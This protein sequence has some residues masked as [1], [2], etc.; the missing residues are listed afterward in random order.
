MRWPNRPPLE[1]APTAQLTRETGYCSTVAVYQI[2]A[3][4]R[5]EQE[6]R[7]HHMGGA[8]PGVTA[9]NWPR[10]LDRP[11]QPLATID[12]T[13]LELDVDSK[14]VKSARALVLFV[15]DFRDMDLDTSQGVAVRWVTQEQIDACPQGEP[16]ADFRP[17]PHPYPECKFGVFPAIDPEDPS[18]E[19]EPDTDESYFGPEPMWDE[20]GEEPD[21]DALPSGPFVLQLQSND[22]FFADPQSTL[23]IYEGGGY[24][25]RQ[26][27][28]DDDP[29]VWAEALAATRELV[30]GEGEVEPGSLNYWGGHPPG[31]VEGPDGMVHVLT[32]VPPGY[33][34]EDEDDL[35]ALSFFAQ[36]RIADDTDWE[37]DDVSEIE[38][39]FV[40]EDDLEET[41]EHDEE[42]ALPLR[43]LV[44]RPL[45]EGCRHH[46]VRTLSLLGPRAVWRNPAD[47]R[48]D[49]SPE[50]KLQL[51]SEDVPS[52]VGR[53]T[54]YFVD[55]EPTWIPAIEGEPEP[56]EP[57]A[58]LLSEAPPPPPTVA[59]SGSLFFDETMA[60][61]VAG[62]ELRLGDALSGQQAQALDGAL[63]AAMS[64]RG[65]ALKLYVAGDTTRGVRAQADGFVLGRSSARLLAESESPVVVD[66]ALAKKTLDEL[67]ALDDEFWAPVRA[68]FPQLEV[69]PAPALHLMSWGPRP[70]AAIYAGTLRQRDELATHTFVANLG[71]EQ[72]IYDTGVDGVLVAHVEFDDVEALSLDDDAV[73][74]Q[75]AGATGIDDPALYLVCLMA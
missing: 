25:Q 59:P 63:Q 4:I 26:S 51:R 6:Q 23:A 8:S 1:P 16:P 37:H 29:P 13:G 24:M 45:A 62:W 64:A 71:A 60:A 39:V 73:A 3:K 47:E 31:T 10:F 67:P 68:D 11:M 49:D 41:A 2:M 65:I 15:D 17:L 55:T 43:P 72:E 32:L 9:E 54:L 44:L 69:T 61:V 42:P 33:P 66:P 21:D 30:A 74:K 19:F 20:D 70:Y 34:P 22:F 52:T 58:A 48:C 14:L 75:L 36:P 12:L 46:D 18:E 57:G 5:S 35:R 38:M 56:T 7:I 28:D 53:G 40:Y 50:F 27:P